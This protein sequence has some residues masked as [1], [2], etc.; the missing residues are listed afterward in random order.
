MLPFFET[1]NPH[2]AVTQNAISAP[3]DAIVVKRLGCVDYDAVWRDMQSFTALRDGNTADEIWLVQHPAVYTVGVA[4]RAAHLPRIPT[5]I[6]V[7]HIDRGGQITYH[8]PGQ[9]IAYVLVDM[10]RRALG[11]RELVRRLEQAV[12]DLLGEYGIDSARRTAAPGVYVGDAK[13]AALGLRIRRSCSY[14]GLA[15]N[16]DM[17]LSPFHAIDPCGFPG[18][19]VARLRDFGVEESVECV[20]DKLADHLLKVLG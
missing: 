13:I 17:D 16:V 10:K 1:D 7:V 3:G 9:V 18:L 2:G 15:L 4:G 6:P 8:G 5:G 19:A 14:H 20:A 11:V 12:I